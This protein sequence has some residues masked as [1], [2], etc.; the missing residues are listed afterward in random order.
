MM[1]KTR[2][3][4]RDSGM[5][6]SGSATGRSIAR[7]LGVN[8][9]SV[10]SVSR[11][12]QT[13][14]AARVASSIAA[15]ERDRFCPTLARERE[16]GSGDALGLTCERLAAAAPRAAMLRGQRGRGPRRGGSKLEILEL[17]LGLVS[18]TC[19]GAASVAFAG[20]GVWGPSHGPTFRRRHSQTA[21]E[22][23]EA[24]IGV[25]AAGT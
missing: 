12:R 6:S 8:E 14:T 23:A 16:G 2:G 21:S 13:A 22:R 15:V 10:G 1:R 7:R 4:S 19:V 5:K 25:D 9:R 3:Y 20:V 18:S 24:A 11:F 17:L